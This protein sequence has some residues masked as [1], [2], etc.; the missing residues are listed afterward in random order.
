MTSRCLSLPAL[1][2]ALVAA[3]LASACASAEPAAPPPDRKPEWV[4]R[5]N[6]ISDE[7]D[8]RVLFAV[9]VA[10][11]NPNRSMQRRQAQM[12]ARNELARSISALVHGMVQHYVSGHRS[13]YEGMDESSSGEYTEDIA[14]QVADQLI[15]GAKQ[16]DDFHDPIDKSYFI[17]YRMDVDDVIRAYSEQMNVA[18]RRELAR[19]RIRADEESFQRDLQAQLHVLDGM[20]AAELDQLFAGL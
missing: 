4:A 11:A 18:F 5:A 17:L 8:S 20:T 3:S 19:Q 13:Y 10:E 1:C 16:W 2:A 12:R 15:A 14:R 9:G 7:G 6:T